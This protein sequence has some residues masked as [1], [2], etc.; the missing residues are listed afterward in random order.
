M[1]T[2]AEE[3]I[4]EGAGIQ[5]NNGIGEQKQSRRSMKTPA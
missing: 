1:C 5:G 3:T 4:A 2:P